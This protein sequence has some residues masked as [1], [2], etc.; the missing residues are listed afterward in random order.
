MRLDDFGNDECGHPAPWHLRGDAAMFLAVFA[1]GFPL[2]VRLWVSY[3][4]SPVG[5]YNE[6]AHG[7]L[8]C[9]RGAKRKYLWALPLPSITLMEVS[10][11]PSKR[12]GR[13]NWGFPKTWRDLRWDRSG[14]WEHSGRCVRVER[15]GQREELRLGRWSLPVRLR[16]WTVQVLE[17]R[18]VLVPMKLSCH[19][20]ACRNG[21]NW[22]LFAEGFDFF[23][24]AP[25]PLR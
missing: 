14:R 8:K 6:Y 19:L 10:S 13:A 25:R 21:G 5:A 22:G 7:R 1:D 24:A 3:S 23:V 16:L 15:G 11:H 12:C 17:G 9:F 18:A 2:G 4:E 20:R